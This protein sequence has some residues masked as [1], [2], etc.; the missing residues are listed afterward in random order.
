MIPPAPY[1]PKDF[2]VIK[3]DGVYHLFY[4]RHN[5]TLPESQTENDF[6]HAVSYDL[7]HW[8]QEPAVLPARP[9]EWDN[10]HVW[11]PTIVEKN[12]VYTMF[13]AGVTHQAGVYDDYQR[14]GIATSTDLY[15][16]TRSDPP[17]YSCDQVPWA[18]CDSLNSLT[19]FRDPFVMPDPNTPGRW[20]LYFTANAASDTVN[21]LVG[22]AAGDSTFTNWS[23]LE[24]LWITHRRYSGSGVAESPHVFQHDGL[25]YL[26][27]TASGANP[28]AYATS[29]DPT[30]D[31]SGWT[32][33]GRI[34]TM[35]GYSTLAWFASEHLQD[36]LNEYLLYS[37]GDRLEMYQMIWTGAVTFYLQQPDPFHV[38]QLGWQADTVVTG[39]PGTLQMTTVAGYDRQAQLEALVVDDNGIATQ[40][41]V[42]SVGVPATLDA[43]SDVVAWTGNLK[44]WPSGSREPIRLLVRT[45]DQTATTPRPIVVL[46]D[47]YPPPALR[48]QR[49]FWAKDTVWSGDH[50]LLG[51]A[52]QSWTGQ[53]V[54]LA[55]STD[56]GTGA[57]IPAPLDV[58]GFPPVLGLVADTTYFDWT[59]L[60]W[61]DDGGVPQLTR[62]V[63]GIAG[64]T[65]RTVRPLV[66]LPPGW[67]NSP[68]PDTSAHF[69]GISGTDGDLLPISP[70]RKP[71][72]AAAFSIHATAP[73]IARLE[74]FDVQG[75]RI[76]LVGP[77]ALGRG[78]ST[79][80]WN[81]R[82]DDGGRV[83]AGIY[84]TRVTAGHATRI[85]RTVVL[86]R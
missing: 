54:P 25:W 83:R 34:G 5:S 42:D 6:G 13:Y 68:P 12:G 45:Q 72:S 30:A 2:A 86:G 74:V 76:A 21:E 48:V 62:L 69:P 57:L 41:P 15:N 44:L 79:I 51:I 35:L 10:L 26:F 32:P 46:P 7:L 70:T 73:L 65:L 4:I 52:A 1:Y 27:Y 3:K 50:V 84:F 56:P 47:P 49:M 37:I 71:G 81:G 61:P 64:D 29:P 40:V 85:T 80:E 63:M 28:I 43:S 36:G 38:V 39:H 9:L 59:S 77:L 19:G 11:A 33:R 18:L 75:R 31:L 82:R 17:V 16:W 67:T 20:L 78:S 58:L 14:I 60:T 55:A 22:I 53:R 8:T 24:P 23:D 66:V